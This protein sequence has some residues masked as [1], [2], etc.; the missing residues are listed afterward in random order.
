[1]DGYDWSITCTA[2]ALCF[3]ALKSWCL[4]LPPLVVNFHLKSV[5]IPANQTPLR[6]IFPP[7]NHPVSFPPTEKD[8]VIVV[9]ATKRLP[10]R[11]NP[12]FLLPRRAQHRGVIQLRT[13]ALVS[14][15]SPSTPAFVKKGQSPA[16]QALGSLHD[17]FPLLSQHHSEEFRLIVSQIA[18]RTAYER[19]T[20]TPFA[21]RPT[22]KESRLGDRFDSE[23]SLVG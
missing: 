16:P 5:E 17:P 21:L 9:A 3:V 1:M 12:P 7:L 18:L 20:P 6:R 2:A 23:S 8:T 19:Y 15:A 10:D 13:S 14:F 22:E 4:L 11:F